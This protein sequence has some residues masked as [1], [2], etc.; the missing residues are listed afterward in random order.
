MAGFPRDATFIRQHINCGKRRC[1]TCG[2]RRYE[3]GPYWYAYWWED[4]RTRSAY[5]G[6]SLPGGRRAERDAR[7]REAAMLPPNA[8]RL[9]GVTQKVTADELRRAYRKAALAN[10]PDHGGSHERM[11]A[12]NVAYKS[13]KRERGWN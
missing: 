9:L 2:G 6:K 11:V 7:R 8:Y 12:V 3:H 5:V 13:I 1:G 10:H 4:G